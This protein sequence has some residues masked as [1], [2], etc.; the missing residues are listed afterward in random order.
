M[1]PRQTNAQDITSPGDDEVASWPDPPAA[2]L[3]AAL[4]ALLARAIPADVVADWGWLP[5][6]QPP[7]PVR[8]GPL[9]AGEV[10]TIDA[11]G[12]KANRVLGLIKLD[13]DARHVSLVRYSYYG[14]DD[15]TVLAPSPA[16]W[17]DAALVVWPKDRA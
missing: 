17:A 10:I 16:W 6:P 9:Q 15:T 12:L 1:K 13:P 7:V 3:L 5:L 8:W 4:D 2:T 11:G 14:D